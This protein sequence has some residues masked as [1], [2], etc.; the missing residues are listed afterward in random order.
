MKKIKNR[1]VYSILILSVLLT[2]CS[3]F[4]IQDPQT[5]LSNEQTFSNLDNMQAF[6]DGVYFK[7][8]QTH[9]NRKAFFTMTDTDEIRMGEYQIRDN[10]NQG[11]FDNYNSFYENSDNPFT[12][13][14]WN[15]RWPVVVLSSQALDVLQ[16]MEK[17]ATGQD[18]ARVKSLIAQASFYRAFV[19]FELAMY[20][21]EV[22]LTQV[23]GDEIKLTGRKPLNEVYAQIESDLKIVEAYSPDKPNASNVRIPTTWAGK[24]MLAKV[25]MYAQEESG[26]RNYAKAKAL[27][28]EIKDRS[29]YRLLNNYADLWTGIDDT[30]AEVIYKLAFNNIYPDENEL[31]WYAGSRAVAQGGGGSNSYMAGYDLVL[32]TNYCREDIDKGGIWEQGDVRKEESIRYS[33]VYN[34][35]SCQAVSGFGNDQLEPHIKKFEDKRI[36]GVKE[37]YYTGKDFFILRYSDILLLLAECLNEEGQTAAAVKIVNDEVRAR[38]W[39]GVLPDEYKWNSGMSKDEFKTKILDERMR[40]LCFE[41]WRRMDLLRTGN[42]VSYVNKHNPWAKANGGPKDDHKRFPIPLV[43]INQNEF[44]SDTDQNPGY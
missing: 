11:A 4:L 25:Y 27:L 10:A 23:L 41:N 6:L 24:A 30:S 35:T 15:V 29:G 22:P 8:K 38:A 44:I 9:V 21:G 19:L 12:A 37:V 28:Q 5:Q 17:T 16:N 36:D 13:E 18:S 14:I 26:F 2:A 7:W 31:Q 20:W 3:D 40:E 42:F 32:P 33:F 1:F 43:E 39:G 34:G